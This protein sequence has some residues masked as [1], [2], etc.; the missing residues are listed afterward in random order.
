MTLEQPGLS[1]DPPN[2]S[3]RERGDTF[4]FFLVSEL[5]FKRLWKKA[6]NDFVKGF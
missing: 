2:W 4:F 1:L 5:R 3:G 6:L